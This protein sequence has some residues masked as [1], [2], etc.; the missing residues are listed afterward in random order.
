M[1][2][3]SGET[4]GRSSHL[5]NSKQRQIYIYIYIFE[6]LREKRRE[7]QREEIH[8]TRSHIY[9]YILP[10]CKEGFLDQ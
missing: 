10:K 6:K 5:N 7:K 8:K 3:W 1:R 4:L 2:S 9:L